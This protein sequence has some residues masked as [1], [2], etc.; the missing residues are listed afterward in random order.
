MA[1]AHDREFAVGQ[2]WEYHTRSSEIESQLIVVKIDHSDQ[3]RIIHISVTGLHL[4][5]PHAPYGY[6]KLLPHLPIAESALQESVT[7]CVGRT[8][9]LPDYTEGYEIWREAFSK[10]EGGYF[11]IPVAECVEYTEQIL[12]Q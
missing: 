4:K 6:G 8:D 9:E 10:G 11:A 5:N 1:T 7:Q 3:G 12:N 2:I